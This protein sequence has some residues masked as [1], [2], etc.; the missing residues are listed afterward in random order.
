MMKICNYWPKYALITEAENAE[1]QFSSF[2]GSAAVLRDRPLA[3]EK[4]QP[5]RAK[6]IAA[7]LSSDISTEG[8][9]CF[10]PSSSPDGQKKRA[11]VSSVSLW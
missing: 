2:P 6:I 9:G 3:N 11:S 1:M 7:L 8:A 10:C 4:H 5:Y